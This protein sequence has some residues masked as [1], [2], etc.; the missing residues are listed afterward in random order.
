MSEVLFTRE[1]LAAF[2]ADLTKRRRHLIGRTQRQRVVD[3]RMIWLVGR[4][5][6]QTMNGR[7]AESDQ[8]LLVEIESA[9][10]RLKDGVYGLCTTCRQRISSSHLCAAP[11]S[12]LCRTC[13][14]SNRQGNGFF[15]GHSL[16]V[17]NPDRTL[18]TDRYREAMSMM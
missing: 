3:A 5:A 6:E 7:I 18:I 4:T 8:K 15:A 13:K 1:Q 11:A 9:L 17:A 16:N 2:H 14:T 10:K 12:R